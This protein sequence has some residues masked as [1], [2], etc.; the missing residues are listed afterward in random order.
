MQKPVVSP[1]T[2]GLRHDGSVI[3][4]CGRQTGH[5]TTKSCIGFSCIPVK[6]PSSA[7][8]LQ[9]LQEPPFFMGSGFQRTERC[10]SL[11]LLKGSLMLCSSQP[12]FR[13]TMINVAS[14]GPSLER[15][16]V[17]NARSSHSSPRE[18]IYTYVPLLQQVQQHTN[19][20]A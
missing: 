2:Q 11:E 16:A 17:G 19:V 20:F 9:S 6:G 18:D 3:H 15:R 10:V 7:P 8:S 5:N 1:F 13:P 14:I 4:R 12:L